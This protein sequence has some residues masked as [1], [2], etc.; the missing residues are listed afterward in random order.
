MADRGRAMARPHPVG[1]GGVSAS[2]FHA[3]LLR[4]DTGPRIVGKQGGDT[5]GSGWP[6]LP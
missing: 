5:D 1:Y 2:G 4:L 3:K 6:Q